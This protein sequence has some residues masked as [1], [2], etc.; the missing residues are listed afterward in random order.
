VT[1]QRFEACHHIDAN[2]RC[3]SSQRSVCDGAESRA[4]VT[5][6]QFLQLCGSAL[7][8]NESLLGRQHGCAGRGIGT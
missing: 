6:L 1:R 3:V 5:A 4:P 8:L 7:D 2:D